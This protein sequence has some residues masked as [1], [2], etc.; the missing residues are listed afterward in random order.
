[1]KIII[2]FLTLAL[3]CFA[4]FAD[5]QQGNQESAS[6]QG[7]EQGQQMQAQTQNQGEE[8]QV[9][10]QEEEGQGFGQLIQQRARTVSEVREMVQQK[11]QEMVQEMQG[12]GEDVQKVY[13][14]QNR[15]R[16]AVHALLAVED[17]EEGIGLQVSEIARE[18]D[19]SVQATI[20]AEEKIQKRNGFVRFFMGGAEDA[21]REIKQQVEQN[22]QR[23]QE[24][25]Q[26]R[27]DCDDCSQEVKDLMQ[28]QVQKIDQEQTR[29]Q[30]LA[31]REEN[32][33]GVFGW[34]R[35]LFGR[36]PL[37]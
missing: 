10:N 2:P 16:E 21:A 34:F 6:Q 14:N 29:L 8:Q 36:L 28:E 20:E 31:E 32:S 9:Q 35:N 33:R 19:N 11:Q 1:M 26:L 30:Q 7:K 13:Q 17:L 15:V 18:F 3:F 25:K 12:L 23:I 24:V 27:E 37:F 4:A 5:A 22:R